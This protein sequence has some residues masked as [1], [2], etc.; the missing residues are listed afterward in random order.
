MN[1]K[2][3]FAFISPKYDLLNHLL[4]F[5]LDFYWRRKMAEIASIYF[6]GK[7]IDMLDIAS[8]TGD[9]AISFKKLKN[10]TKIIAT[11]F[12]FEMLAIA[13]AKCERHKKEISFTCTDGEDLNFKDGSFD[14]V[15]NAFALR[16][17]KNLEKAFKEMKRILRPEGL[18][19]S[20]EFA[21]PKNIL[22][23]PFF[24]IY[25]NY[26][27]PLIG[28]LLSSDYRAYKYLSN[29]IQEFMSPGEV[30][31]L[32]S[33][34]GFKEVYYIPLTFGIVNIYIGKS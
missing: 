18:C 1:I 19:M 9:V 29:S 32:I 15:T 7:K 2:D 31:S 14:L 5:G 16:N 13:K 33:S 30:C 21:R 27:L 4:S 20:L 22:F 17:I 28:A 25:L 8:G 6:F 34:A 12:C 23:K 11:D 3:M 10:I 24:F 26:I